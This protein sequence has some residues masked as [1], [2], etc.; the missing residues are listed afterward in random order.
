L[1]LRRIAQKNRIPV[2]MET[3]DRGMLDIERFDLYP[4][5]PIF[6]GKLEGPVSPEQLLIENPKELVLRIIDPSQASQRGAYS[7][8]KMGSEIR[9][10]PQLAEDVLLGGA[11]AAKACRNILLG[12]PVKTGRHYIDIDEIIA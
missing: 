7:L 10:W 1:A 4:D 9:T 8:T 12:N 11:S 2:V 5:L 6:H 3:S